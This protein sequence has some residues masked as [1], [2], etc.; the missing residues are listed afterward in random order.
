MANKKRGGR[1]KGA[2]RKKG[3]VSEETRIRQALKSKLLERVEKE[4]GGLMD[5]MINL[6]KGI[7]VEGV[8][9]EGEVKLYIKAPNAEI[10]KYLTDQ[11][12]GKAKETLDVHTVKTLTEEEIEAGEEEAMSEE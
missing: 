11:T 5:T 7:Q 8:D 10:L 1:R 9:S 6:A 4:F 3:S 2:G 12:L